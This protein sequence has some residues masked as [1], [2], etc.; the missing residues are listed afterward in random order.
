MRKIT[1]HGTLAF[2]YM[3]TYIYVHIKRNMYIRTSKKSLWGGFKLSL[4]LLV[5]QWSVGLGQ[6]LFWVERRAQRG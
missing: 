5:A 2:A 6:R 3:C 1:Q 4:T